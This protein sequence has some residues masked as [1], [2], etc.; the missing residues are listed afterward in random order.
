[1]YIKLNPKPD[2]K[3]KR[4]NVRGGLTLLRILTPQTFMHMFEWYAP[5]KNPYVRIRTSTL[6]EIM[7][8]RKAHVEMRL[9]Q[10]QTSLHPYLLDS[11]LAKGPATRRACV[12]LGVVV[13][14][15]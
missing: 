5:P 3:R 9:P 2:R 13:V 15:A 1:M 7:Q 14:R 12:Q 11:P 10:M 8:R 6:G 4:V